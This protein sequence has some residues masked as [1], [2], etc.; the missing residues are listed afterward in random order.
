MKVSE[1]ENQAAP[2]W[3]L[4]QLLFVLALAFAVGLCAVSERWP[5]EEL[6]GLQGSVPVGECAVGSA[7]EV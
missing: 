7:P 6:G 4:V 5:K 1:S 3:A 2:S